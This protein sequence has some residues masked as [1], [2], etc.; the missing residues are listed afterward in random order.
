V[1]LASHIPPGADIYSS[2]KDPSNP[3]MMF[4]PTYVAPFD[5]LV[6]A[7]ADVIVLHATGHTHM[8]EFRVYATGSS[9]VPD[10]GVPA[11][12]P[13]FG[14]NP[15]FVSLRLDP[16]GNPLDYTAYAFTGLA[17]APP[18]PGTNGGVQLFDFGAVYHQSAVTGAAMLGAA[19]LIAS[20]STVRA[21]W[22]L[23]YAGGRPGQNPTSANWQGYWCA[24]ANLEPAAYAACMQH[25]PSGSP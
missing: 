23:N 14:N 19:A 11:V 12:S 8:S 21:A 9:G 25:P 22:E 6:R 5:S 15:G 16:S 3:T 1:W 13:I 24:I 18:R 7:Y 10:V 17:S 20:D 2:L 4:T